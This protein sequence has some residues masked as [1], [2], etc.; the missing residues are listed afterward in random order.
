MY[1]YDF[2]T[3]QIKH[4]FD[5]IRYVVNNSS[6]QIDCEPQECSVI[7]MF[8]NKALF[9]AMPIE[10]LGNVTIQ[11]FNSDSTGLLSIKGYKIFFSIHED[12]LYLRKSS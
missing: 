1:N 2:K 3:K 7:A 10:K 12:V 5:S 6:L 4:I 9:V 8:S 11:G